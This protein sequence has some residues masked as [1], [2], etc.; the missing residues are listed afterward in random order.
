M[1]L[2]GCYTFKGSS[3]LFQSKDKSCRQSF[4][5]LARQ[6]PFHS[7]YSGVLSVLQLVSKNFLISFKIS[8]LFKNLKKVPQHMR[9]K[10]NMENFFGITLK[11]TFK[12]IETY[13]VSMA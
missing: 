2:E 5:Y 12:I 1:E 6:S 3:T 13:L 10:L 11:L 4:T 7:I 9:N 8:N